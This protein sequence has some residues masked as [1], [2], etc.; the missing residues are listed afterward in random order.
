MT[1]TSTG[2]LV[3]FNCSSSCSCI[4]SNSEA[5][6]G[7]KAEDGWGVDDAA[8]AMV[9]GDEGSRTNCRRKSNNPLRFVLSL[10]TRPAYGCNILARRDNGNAVPENVRFTA[11]PGNP[12][13][14]NRK[15]PRD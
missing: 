13:P 1:S 10:I 15:L 6:D 3:A 7:S 4:A 14:I 8:F 5:P 2:A 11:P 9:G 12:L